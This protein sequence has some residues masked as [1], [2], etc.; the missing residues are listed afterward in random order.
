[1]GSSKQTKRI[2]NYLESLTKEELISLIFKFAPESFFDSINSQFASQSEAVVIFNKVSKAIKVLLSDEDLLYNPSGFE[3]E[4]LKQ[5]EKLRG[6]WDKLP[7]QIGDLII[8]IVE[9]VEKS[10]DDGYLY[11]E[12]YDKEDDYF[13]SKEVNDYI[14]R[15]LSNLSEDVKVSY[16]ENLQE[17][18]RNSAYS[19]FLD[20]ERRLSEL[21]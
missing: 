11:I 18:L 13:E 16:V 19:T 9:D 21:L 8:K 5:L 12:N 15:F 14:F 4:L 7:T 1:M 2:R 10:F 20:V 17:I 3:R 6:L